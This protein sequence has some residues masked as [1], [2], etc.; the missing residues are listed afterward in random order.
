M[1]GN[2]DEGMRRDKGGGELGSDKRRCGSGDEKQ[3]G[4]AMYHIASVA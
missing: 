1:P 4:K 3:V 2:S